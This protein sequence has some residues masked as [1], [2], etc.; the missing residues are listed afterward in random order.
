MTSLNMSSIYYC[1]I[2]KSKDIIEYDE[3][4]ECP[5]CK[6]DFFKDSLGEI[7][8][9]NRLSVQELDGFVK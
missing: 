2:C 3:Y 4:I 6:L 5:R 1:P 7:D 8:D 9:E